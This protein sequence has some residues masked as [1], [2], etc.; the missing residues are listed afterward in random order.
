MV[1]GYKFLLVLL[2][3][4]TGVASAQTG[5]TSPYS[6]S[7]L[8]ELKFRGFSQ[9]TA[10][11][12]TS[13]ASTLNSSFTA[14]NPASY[15][16]LKFTVYDVGLYS[17]LGKLQTDTR[18]ANTRAGN[19]SHFA[20]AFPFET[21]RPMA[22]SFGT[23]Q[24]SDVG[25]DIKNTVSTDTPSYYDLYRGTGGINR[26]Y[27]GYGL[28]VIKNLNVGFNAN[29]NFGKI[30]SLY[31]KVYP[32]TD[33]NFSYSDESFFAYNG[34]DYD[35][36]VQ[37]TV[38]NSIRTRVRTKGD[39]SGIKKY[40]TGKL[41]HTFAASFHTQSDLVGNGYTYT[42]TFFG[43]KF[44]QG[45]LTP[46]DTIQ[47]IDNQTNTALKPGGFGVGYSMSNGEKWS[48]NL[49]YEKNFWSDV[50]NDINNKQFFDNE[51]YGFG[52]SVIP[53]PNYAEVGQFLKKVRYSAG[54]S[55]EKMY[56]NFFDQQIA[57]LGISFGLAI[58]VTKVVR[59]EDEKI[60]IVSRVNLTAEYIRR[61]TTTNNL[62]QEDY[63][64]IGIGLNLN[65]KWFTKRKYR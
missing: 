25:Y 8:G 14:L 1:K 7:G 61:G 51:R 4:F 34:I 63:I 36:G 44:E 13:I 2:I 30:Q 29:F 50:T 65:D 38:Q 15:A 16:N 37:Y 42:E 31:A 22:V 64:N 54:F 60:P 57:E 26:V 48:L 45:I 53:T 52:F 3:S 59:V 19:L 23:N 49:E 43:R 56:Y 28:E 24:Y 5:T 41:N 27:V 40:E 58:P 20:M 6:I 39:T 12:R 47:F 55:Y 32:L 33:D 10:M 18:S 17:S 46:I 11:G 35:L 9:H 21:D 62:I